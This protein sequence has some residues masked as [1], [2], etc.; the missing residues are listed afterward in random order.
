MLAS[1]FINS[2]KVE[3]F[4]PVF[5]EYL[6]KLH[7]F[8]SVGNAAFP[9]GAAEAIAAYTYDVSNAISSARK[10]EVV[11]QILE[12]VQAMEALSPKNLSKIS[13]LTGMNSVPQVRQNAEL[14]ALLLRQQLAL[15]TLMG[16]YSTSVK[17]FSGPTPKVGETEKLIDIV[18]VD[19]ND[20]GI[21][22]S[23][24]TAIINATISL[25]K[26]ASQAYGIP[27]VEPRIVFA[28]SGSDWRVR[29]QLSTT[30]GGF[31]ISC[32]TFYYSTL[33]TIPSEN[34]NV[35]VRVNLSQTAVQ[36]SLQVT[37]DDG[38][39]ERMRGRL[40]V[41]F[42]TIVAHGVAPYED[43]YQ[44]TR[45]ALVRHKPML[46]SQPEA[47]PDEEDLDAPDAPDLSTDED[48]QNR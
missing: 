24:I 23:R 6:K 46:L 16:L 20:E 31:I 27:Y 33:K 13:T 30:V 5:D 28:E 15:E 42:D 29:I 40:T 45:N 39:A 44:S 14:L 9:P 17:L 19:F 11:N 8:T 34:V 1:Q 41:D 36:Q 37:N 7:F 47:T 43:D 25:T 32:L 3:S 10:D 38:R 22:L 21:T 12:S 4:R 26:H 2:L 35:N 18:I 48:T